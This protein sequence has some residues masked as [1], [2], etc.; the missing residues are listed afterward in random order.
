MFSLFRYCER[1]RYKNVK[2]PHSFQSVWGV[3]IGEHIRPT[4]C[5]LDAKPEVEFMNESMRFLV[6]YLCTSLQLPFLISWGGAHS[7]FYAF[8]IGDLWLLYFWSHVPIWP[9]IKGKMKANFVIMITKPLAQSLGSVSFSF[10][11][12]NVFRSSYIILFWYYSCKMNKFSSS[13][14]YIQP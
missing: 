7:L 13:N 2:S 11:H 8:L 10:T 4:L 1:K 14:R 12:F 6:S 5:V 3:A 9:I